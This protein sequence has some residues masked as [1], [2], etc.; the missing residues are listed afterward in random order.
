M[1]P[2]IPVIWPARNRD[3]LA[4]GYADCALL[5]A[6]F[7][8][9]LWRAVDGF[10]FEHFEVRGDEFPDVEGAVV[11]ANGRANAKD[12]AWLA[13]EVDRLAWA[14][15]I[16]T[17]D[18]EWEINW[19]LFL[20]QYEGSDQRRKLWI[21]QPL[22]EHA[23]VDYM[24]P[25]GWYPRTREELRTRSVQAQERQHPWF[26]AGQVTHQRRKDCV[27]R[28]IKDNRGV[29]IQTGGFMQGVPNEEYM[30]LLASSKLVPCPSGPVTVD[31]ARPLSAMEAGCVPIVDMRRTHG[32][33]FDYWTLCFGEGWPMPSVW[34]WDELPRALDQGLRDWP[35]NANRISAWWQNWKRQTAYALRDQL[36][37]LRRH[38]EIERGEI[39]DRVT[40]VITTSPIPSHPSTAIIEQTIASVREHLPDCEIIIGIDGVRPEQ[41]EMTTAYGEYVRRLLWKC[42]FDWHNVLPVMMSEWGH[43]ANTTRLALSKVRTET[44]L[45]LEHDTPLTG[46]EGSINWEGLIRLIEDQHANVIRL[47]QDIEIHPDH[48][49]TMIDQTNQYINGVPLRRSNVWWQRPHL[50]STQFY[51][52]MLDHWFPT[53]SRTMIEDRIYSPMHLEC[54]TQREGWGRWKVWV[55]H[56]DHEPDDVRGIRR[57]G[58]LD[59]RGDAP[60]YGMIYG[61]RPEQG[62]PDAAVEAGVDP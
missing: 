32:D 37:D 11:V 14:L 20:S 8:E 24:L 1:K 62:K 25:G 27:A 19:P 26:F 35:R 47:H 39:D 29:L 12:A 58:H 51:R 21:M 23:G 30:K 17:G 40:V 54:I 38:V 6:I 7:D 15:V 33:Q 50:A 2:T 4:R 44:M 52:E 31:T 16:L 60:K 55:Y 49:S 34:E 10:Q 46:G 57:S 13:T 48:A 28:L 45:F 42:N 22:P 18:E 41:A 61:D 43:Q 56:P 9:S 5:E 53:H 36:Y 3:Y 59:G